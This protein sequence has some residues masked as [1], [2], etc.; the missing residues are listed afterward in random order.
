M[1]GTTGLEV[2]V[3]GLGAGH[4]GDPSMSESDVSAL[5]NGAV[6]MGVTLIDSARSYGLS[7]ERIGRHLAGRRNEII[8]STKVGYGIRGFEDWT[9]PCI[10]AGIEEALLR[11]RTDRID[12]VHFHSCPVEVLRRGEVIEAM[13][14]SVREGKVRVAAYSGDGDALTY[15]IGLG[16]F[17]S[18]QTSVNLCNQRVIDEGLKYARAASL[19]VIAK[20]PVANSP[21]KHALRPVGQYVEEYWLRLRKMDLDTHG[22]EWPELALRFAANV[23]GVHTCIVGTTRLEHLRQNVKYASRGPL[24]EAI[25]REIREQFELNDDGWE[26]EV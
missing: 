11:L 19:G 1:F 2:P 3:L 24:E 23:P 21:W 9:G 20:R 12:I 26:D 8:L 13:T 25:V 6:D 10:T 17:G 16:V 7:E 22:L 14:R 5:L 18:I 4:I 15:A